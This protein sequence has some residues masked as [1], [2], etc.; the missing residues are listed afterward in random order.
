[1][2]ARECTA[3]EADGKAGAVGD[4]HGDEARENGVHEAE[5]C[6]ADIHEEFCERGVRAEMRR[7]DAVV[8]KE[9]GESDEDTAADDEWK[10]V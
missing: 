8:I 10:H 5:R 4:G 2:C 6:A 3:D 1:M 7:V 9:E